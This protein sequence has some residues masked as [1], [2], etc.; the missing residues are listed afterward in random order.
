MQ[1]SNFGALF[2]YCSNASRKPNCTKRIL[3]S[4]RDQENVMRQPEQQNDGRKPSASSDSC[5]S[6]IK[7]TLQQTNSNTKE[8]TLKRK[9]EMQPIVAKKSKASTKS[10]VI[11]QV[12]GQQKLGSFFRVWQINWTLTNRSLRISL[13][14]V[15]LTL[16]YIEFDF[17]L[18][19]GT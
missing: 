17:F 19:K 3:E 4:S 12:K 15:L 16:S 7:A 9:A 2:C 5:T 11:P 10:K 8:S 6:S 18:G 13:L 1:C 14:L